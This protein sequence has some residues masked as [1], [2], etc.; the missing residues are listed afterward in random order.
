[1]LTKL[2]QLL[3]N[4]YFTQPVPAVVVQ[5]TTD[6]IL[7]SCIEAEQHKIITPI[8]VGRKDKIQAA[9]DEAKLDISRYQLIETAHSHEAVEISAKLVREKQADFIIKGSVHTD[10]LMGVL[11][12]KSQ[13]LRTGRRMSHVWL[14]ESPTYHKLLTLTDCALN[15]VPDLLTK[16]DI[17]QNAID[18]AHAIG[19]ETPKVAILS[20]VEEVKPQMISTIDAAALCKMADRG[21][22]TGAILDGPLAFDNAISQHSADIKH[23]HSPVTGDVD[24]LLVPDL[25]AGNMLG[26]QLIYLGNAKAAGIVMGSKVPIVLTSR[27]DAELDRLY[28]IALG[29]LVAQQTKQ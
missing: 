6:I 5:P 11:V 13:N 10:E 20:A 23:I 4:N 17:L 19:I 9:A 8:L 7:Q 22:I 15:V 26:K 18:F 16:K 3:D 29:A 2:S 24:I 28:S 12:D 27:S 25:E 14:M 1:M 21:Q